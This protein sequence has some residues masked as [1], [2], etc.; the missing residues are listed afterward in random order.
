[1]GEPNLTLPPLSRAQLLE[2]L[3]ERDVI[4]VQQAQLIGELVD[5]L[6]QAETPKG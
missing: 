3:G 5:R 1:M 4:I 6:K 2:M